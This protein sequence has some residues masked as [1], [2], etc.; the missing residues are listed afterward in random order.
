[1][2]GR[3]LSSANDFV[4]R[5]TVL[6]MGTQAHVAA[7]PDARKAVE[8]VCGQFPEYVGAVRVLIDSELADLKPDVNVAAHKLLSAVAQELVDGELDKLNRVEKGLRAAV[9]AHD[10]APV[11]DLM[12][13]LP[14]ALFCLKQPLA[15]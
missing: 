4:L 8:R 11:E 12:P 7:A 9:E 15:G 14:A 6:T 3:R 10:A 5:R 2:R 1:M 13:G